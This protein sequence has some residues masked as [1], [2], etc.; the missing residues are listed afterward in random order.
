MNHPYIYILLVIVITAVV[1]VIMRTINTPT[2][3]TFWEEI[4]KQNPIGIFTD[5]GQMVI[6]SV[7]C[8]DQIGWRMCGSIRLSRVAICEVLPDRNDKWKNLPHSPQFLQFRKMIW[9]NNWFLHSLWSLR[10]AGNRTMGSS[11]P[12]FMTTPWDLDE[13]FP[14]SGGRGFGTTVGFIISYLKDP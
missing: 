10:Q 1:I 12:W 5:A 7:Y 2:L 4:Q 8:F 14:S 9:W 6:G 11:A 13:T 3:P